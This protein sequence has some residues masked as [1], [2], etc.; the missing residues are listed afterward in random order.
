M[1][2]YIYQSSIHEL[3][4]RVRPYV[5]TVVRHK[6]VSTHMGH[7]HSYDVLRIC[8]RIIRNERS[9]KQIMYTSREYNGLWERRGVN[10]TW[11]SKVPQHV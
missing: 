3:C 8:M 11:H 10:A 2:I 4:I 7:M 9:K 5:F 6:S 1:Y